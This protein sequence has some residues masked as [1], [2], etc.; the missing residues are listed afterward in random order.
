M[1]KTKCWKRNSA[2]RRGSREAKRKLGS[3]VFKGWGGKISRFYAGR[4][5]RWLGGTTGGRGLYSTTRWSG[6]LNAQYCH[7]AFQPRDLKLAVISS[8]N[9]KILAHHGKKKK[10]N[11][12]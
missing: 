12:I 3:G 9:N 6:D 7:S 10:E 1:G 4:D 11:N 5:V 8:R 2:G